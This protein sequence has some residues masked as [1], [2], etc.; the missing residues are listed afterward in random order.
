[1]VVEH[2][3]ALDDENNHTLTMSLKQSK[4]STYKYIISE[5]MMQPSTAESIAHEVFQ[6]VML[7][8]QN[9]IH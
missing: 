8:N 1:M 3:H 9:M 6:K 4:S 5:N 7:I 2:S